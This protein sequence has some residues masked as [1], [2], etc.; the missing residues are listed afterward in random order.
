MLFTSPVFLLLFMPISL[1]VYA[2]TPPKYRRSVIFILSIL[3]YV[4][5][6]IKRPVC[7]VFLLMCAAFTYCASFAV[8][9]VK[10]RVVMIL[11]V[12]VMIVTLVMLRLL[13]VSASEDAQRL[14]PIGASF[15][16][17]ASVSCI[18]DVG[19]GDVNPPKSFFETLFYISYFPVMIAGPVIRY[20][21]FVRITD[22]ENIR[23]SASGVAGGIQL[24]SMGFIKRVAIAA[25]L[26]EAIDRIMSGASAYDQPLSLP[27][28]LMLGILLLISVFYSFAGYS[29]MA[30]GIS[31]MLGIPLACDFGSC[32]MAYTV[33]GYADN[34]MN[35]LYRWVTDYLIQP[36][37]QKL[38]AR[39]EFLASLAVP[40]GFVF[41][42]FWYRA[43]LTV[44]FAL[45]PLVVLV[46]LDQN[47]KVT[48]FL[49]KNV[50]TRT[51]G[52]VVTWVVMGSFWLLIR[53]HS[54]SSLWEG[55]SHMSLFAP[56]QSYNMYLIL[57]NREFLLVGLMLIIVRMPFLYAM[58]AKYVPAIAEKNAERA[59]QWIWTGLLTVTFVFTMVYLLPQYPSI[60]AV[61]FS[62]ITL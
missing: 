51:L 32:A 43:G 44:L 19:R 39:S 48:A 7:I 11:S 40:M 5:S 24:F 53:T 26:D 3:F 59:A 31:M 9:T 20:K 61:P 55:M 15:Y 54:V 56:L 6:N 28:I 35:S 14:L 30:R 2:L 36:L 49:S 8:M 62:S 57:F 58:V 10:K 50:L 22:S 23:F 34:F 16:L 45:I 60:A 41:I 42:I 27:V 4:F 37:K 38:E 47:R 29:D 18:V 12:C 46:W 33:T 17:L 25:L 1:A 52:R 13:S 21:E